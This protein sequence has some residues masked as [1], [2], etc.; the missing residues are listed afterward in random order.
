[1]TSK[2]L[3][4][5]RRGFLKATG[6]VAAS[7]SLPSWLIDECTAQETKLQAASPTPSERVNLALIGCGGQGRSD[8]RNA[9]RH[10]KIVAVC[11]VDIRRLGNAR[12]D[13]PGADGYSDF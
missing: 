3:V 2:S 4:T 10:G 5:S 11:D 13:F 8:A 7:T 9:Q 1:M 6:A 12:K